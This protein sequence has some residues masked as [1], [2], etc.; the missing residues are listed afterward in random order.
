[1]GPGA[2]AA[3]LEALE[4]VEGFFPG[5]GTGGGSFPGYVP[6]MFDAA[7]QATQ[8]A[9]GWTRPV[10]ARH[11]VSAHYGTP[12]GWQAGYHTGVD[13]ALPEGEPVYAVGPGTVVLAGTSGDYGETVVT[14]MRDGHHVL[15]AHLSAVEAA[16][17]DELR[18]GERIGA[19]GNTGRSTGPHLHFEVRSG[20]EYGT[21]IDPLDYLRRNG[22]AID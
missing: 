9:G 7:A 17:G 11:P 12:G 19:S 18:G 2:G 6:W 1:P 15:Y 16:V 13:F 22:V 14:R 20:R 5:T 8:T 4:V 10:D 21:D 3:A